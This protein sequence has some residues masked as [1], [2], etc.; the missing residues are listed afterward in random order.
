MN[1]GFWLLVAWCRLGLF[2]PGGLN[3]ITSIQPLVSGIFYRFSLPGLDLKKAA[4][5]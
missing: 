1:T 4:A 3:E 2:V 5:I